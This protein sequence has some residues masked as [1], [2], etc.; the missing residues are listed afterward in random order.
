MQLKKIFPILIGT[1][2]LLWPALCLAAGGNLT[3]REGSSG[4]DAV[5]VVLSTQEDLTA[6]QFGIYYDAD[7]LELIHVRQG[8]ALQGGLSV[9]NDQEPG[10]VYFA[11]ATAN[12]VFPGEEAAVLTLSF[13]RKGEGEAQVAFA[14]DFTIEAC[15]ENSDIVPITVAVPGIQMP[16]AA[17]G[18]EESSP[19]SQPTPAPQPRPSH[20]I[21]LEE[22]EL[23]IE[24]GQEQEL[25]WEAQDPEAKI[26]WFSSNERVAT[27]DETGRITAHAPGETTITAMS[28][29]ARYYA[30]AQVVVPEEK[31]PAGEQI[32]SEMETL[33]DPITVTSGTAQTDGLYVWIIILLCL[34]GL[35][36]V[37]IWRQ[38][39][40]KDMHKEK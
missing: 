9:I 3:L 27:V 12:S 25:D 36:F 21:Q 18:G 11:W 22:T 39:R 40:K 24:Q 14:T 32:Q 13:A 30:E 17:D 1:L 20:G 34:L 35:C 5:E 29:D 15:D 19:P 7:N 31:E 16:A 4:Q 8:T 38:K 33:V 28:E 10:A 6:L 2:L 23:S 37:G 26:Q